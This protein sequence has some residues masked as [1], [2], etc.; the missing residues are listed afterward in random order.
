MVSGDM[1]GILRV[2]TLTEHSE[3]T[4]FVLILI[5]NVANGDTEYSEWQHLWNMASGDTYGIWCVVTLT[6]HGEMF[7]LGVNGI[8]HIC[9]C[10]L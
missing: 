8:T 7:Q 1:Y 5:L 10:W 2:V 9:Q 3:V 6:E 4:L